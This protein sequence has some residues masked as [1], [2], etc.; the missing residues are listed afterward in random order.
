MDDANIYITRHSTSCNNRNLGKN[1]FNPWGLLDYPSYGK[2]HKINKDM[3][4]S[5][6][7]FSVVQMLALKLNNKKKNVKQTK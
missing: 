1:H 7:S 6:T 5:I 2:I 4:P 3:E